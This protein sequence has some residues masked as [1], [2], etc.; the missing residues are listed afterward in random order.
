MLVVG[1]L[2]HDVVVTADRMPELDETLVGRAVDYLCG[3]KGGNQAV[4]AA[5]HGAPTAMAGRVG[6]DAAGQTLLSNLKDAGVDCSCIVRAEDER[7]G[8]SVAI[9]TG[10]GDYGAVIVSAANRAIDPEAI[11]LPAS[12][13]VVLLQNEIPESVNTA[14]A[15]RAKGQGARVV[16]NAAP[17]RP[18]ETGLRSAVDILI[19]NRGE[20]AAMTG[21]AVD[22]VGDAVDVATSLSVDGHDVIFTLGAEGAVLAPAEGEAEHF[23]AFDADVLSTHGAGDAFVGALAARLALG[24][25]LRD[26]LRYAQAVAALHVSCSAEARR[27]ITAEMALRLAEI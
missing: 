21:R 6:G 26:A 25:D 19:L 13:E 8:M 18:F 11:E 14:V 17:A 10:A 3:G 1:A 22:S 2:H 15:E 23:P 16:L 20:A 5:R 27:S 9:V 12:V 24:N 7:S 4:A